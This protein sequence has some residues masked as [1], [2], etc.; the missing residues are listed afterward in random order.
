MAVEPEVRE[1]VEAGRRDGRVRKLERL[2]APKPLLARRRTRLC[3]VENCQIRKA[4][5]PPGQDPDTRW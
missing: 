4:I 2:R 1:H 5:A 3:P